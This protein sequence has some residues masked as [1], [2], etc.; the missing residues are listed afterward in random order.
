MAINVMHKEQIVALS[1]FIAKYS[2]PFAS[3]KAVVI[4]DNNTTYS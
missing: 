2:Y 3:H 4:K 1:E